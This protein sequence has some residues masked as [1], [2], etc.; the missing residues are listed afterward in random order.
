[1]LKPQHIDIYLEDVRAALAQD[2]SDAGVLKAIAIYQQ[3]IQ[4]FPEAS[5][6]PYLAVGYLAVRHGFDD[7]AYTLLRKARQIEPHN[8][9]V[10]TLLDFL[11][12][13]NS[14]TPIPTIQSLPSLQEFNP[15]V[16]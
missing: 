9:H 11:D 16:F 10:K 5:A 14:I 3:A 8:P 15:N 6:E 13:E 7:E 1:M 4:D 12:Q 2:A